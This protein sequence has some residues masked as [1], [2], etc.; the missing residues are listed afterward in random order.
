MV[1]GT[2]VSGGDRILFQEN[3]ES[4]K[5]DTAKWDVVKQGEIK[6]IQEVR[7]VNHNKVL[8][9]AVG[10]GEYGFVS[11]CNKKILKS[12]G[13]L[14]IKFREY[15]RTGNYTSSKEAL[16]RIFD[17]DMMMF[18]LSWCAGNG[19]MFMKRRLKAKDVALKPVKMKKYLN[20]WIDWTIKYGRS[21]DEPRLSVTARAGNTKIFNKT[22]PID[23][24]DDLK[25]KFKVW[26]DDIKWN[27]VRWDDIK[28][29]S[30]E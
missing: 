9:Q 1:F 24:M 20:R 22:F 27:W 13:G 8:V 11:I 16:F 21:Q 14:T 29:L 17:G 19:T 5:I 18:S 4:G 26:N 10:I 30:G 3:W 23:S 15:R 25:I 7:S 2:L 12:Y 6:R 28:V